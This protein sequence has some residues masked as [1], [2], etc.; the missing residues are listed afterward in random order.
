MEKIVTL[1]T[2]NL[3]YEIKNQVIRRYTAMS[4]QFDYLKEQQDQFLLTCFQGK[5][6]DSKFKVL[7]ALNSFFQIVIG[8]I[9]SSAYNLS[10]C[11]LGTEI[12]INFG[13]SIR[14]DKARNSAVQ[15]MHADFTKIAGRYGFS[16]PLLTANRSSDLIYKIAMDLKDNR[17]NDRTMD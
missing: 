5:W 17:P 15:S 16:L 10:E 14:F 11:G 3:E 2:K 4:S 8:P 13:K 1:L 9:S 12:P 7:F 6:T